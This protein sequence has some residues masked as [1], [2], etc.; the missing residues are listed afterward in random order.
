[1]QGDSTRFRCKNPQLESIGYPLNVIDGHHRLEKAF[2]LGINSLSAYKFTVNQHLAFLTS[3]KGY[4]AYIK[5][6]NEK[7]QNEIRA[8]NII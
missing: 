4:T 6:W 1:M 8:K 2:R 7:I 3:Q 5:Y